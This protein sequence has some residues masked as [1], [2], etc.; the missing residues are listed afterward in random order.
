MKTV[1][2]KTSNVDA[3][4]NLTKIANVSLKKSIF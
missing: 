4:D 2:G 1:E 3:C